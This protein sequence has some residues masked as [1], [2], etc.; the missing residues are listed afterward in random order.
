M[1]LIVITML[2]FGLQL[3]AQDGSKQ[4]APVTTT[5]HVNFAP[6]GVIR[7]TTSSSN[8][9]VEAWDRPEV[10][11]TTTKSSRHA[12]CLD[13]VRVAT[14]RRSDTELAVSTTVPSGNFFARLF[15]RTC[16]AAVEQH[17]NAPRN[18]RLVIHHGAGYV[19]VSRISGE[20]EATSRSGDIVLMLPDPGPYS[21][22]AQSKFGSV[23]SDFAGTAHREK[24]LGEQFAGANPPASRRIYLRIGFGGI[25]I[26]EVPSTPEAPVAAS[27]Q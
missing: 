14:E 6:G 27:G 23:S 10:E 7:L 13:D 4:P 5:D 1:K 9:F 12:R 18:S 19:L 15:G 26:K 11:I 20:I 8:L 22:D 25:T 16:S 2:V 3:F 24:L 17:V 21:I